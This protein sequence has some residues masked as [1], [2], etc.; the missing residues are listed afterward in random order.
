MNRTINAL[1]LVTAS[2]F[3]LLTAGCGTIAQNAANGGGITDSQIRDVVSRVANHQVHPLSD[4]D[5]SAVADIGAAKAAKAPEGIMWSYP[6]GVA[7]F[8]VERSADVTSDSV[9]DQFVVQH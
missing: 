7:L 5:Y 2:T 3:L 9:P 6:W 1:C 8:G 4:G